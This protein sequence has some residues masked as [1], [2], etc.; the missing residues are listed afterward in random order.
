MWNN[1]MPCEEVIYEDYNSIVAEVRSALRI[2]LKKTRSSPVSR[3]LNK[4]ITY[5]KQ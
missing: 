5:G 1:T 2:S 3:E 4:H